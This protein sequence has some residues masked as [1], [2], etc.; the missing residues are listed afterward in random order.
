MKEL[1]WLALAGALGTLS[2]Y[3]LSLGVHRFTGGNFPWPT[4][5]VN[6]VGCFCFAFIWALLEH[7]VDGD[8][9]RQ[10][11]LI[12]LT[13]FFGAFT[14]FST[15][16]FDSGRLLDDDRFGAAAGNLVAQ[17][18]LGLAAIFL[19]LKVATMALDVIQRS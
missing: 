19:G 17:N 18:L 7:R 14:T 16:A 13:G 9:L 12:V 4:L 2:R 15:F 3:G 11:R 1:L 6:V 8:Q 10:L 5:V